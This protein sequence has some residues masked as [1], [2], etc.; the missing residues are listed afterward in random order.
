M[1]P[2]GLPGYAVSPR[3]QRMLGA[4]VPA[5]PSVSG[6]PDTE[7]APALDVYPNALTNEGAHFLIAR[8]G[9]TIAA[10]MGRVALD[11]ALVERNG[12][13]LARETWDAIAIAEG[14]RVVIRATVAGRGFNPLAALLSIAVL[15][16]APALGAAFASTSAFSS[17][18]GGLGIT[19]AAG[20]TALQAGVTAAIGAAGMLIVNTV[21]PPR[22]PDLGGGAG[23][24]V[25]Q[26]SISGGRNPR[27][28]FAPLLLVLGEHRVFPDL[29][30]NPYTEF[31]GDDQ[32]LAQVFDWGLGELDISDIRIGD[33]LL[34]EF[35]DVETSYD[36]PV[37]LVHGNVNT[38][39]GGE[40]EDMDPITRTTA[41]GTGRIGVDLV[42]QHFRSEDDG[43]L[44]GREVDFRIEHRVHGSVGAWLSRTETLSTPDGADARNLVRR[45]VYF[46]VAEGQWDVRVRRT[47]DY[48]ADDERI[49]H[50]AV[51]GALRSYQ[52]DATDWTGR[53]PYAVRIR[54]SGQLQGALDRV[55]G[56]ARQQFQTWAG[57]AWTDAA[58]ASRN[59]AAVLRGYWL[60]WAEGEDKLAGMHLDP[61]TINHDVLGGWYE[62]CDANGLTCDLVLTAQRD[63]DAMNKLIAQCGWATVDRQAGEWSVIWESEDEPVSA[64]ITPA[65]IVAGSLGVVYN[66]DNLADEVIVDYID[67]ESGYQ[68]NTLRRRVDLNVPPIRPVT[69]RLEGVTDGEAAARECNRIAAAQVF[70][71]RAIAWEM[72]SEGLSIRRGRVVALAHDLVG[73]TSGGRLVAID[74]ARTR[75]T[76]SPSVA[77]EG[78]IWIWDLMGDVH[79]SAYTG[80]GD[81]ILLADALPA[82]P[83]G[84]DDDPLAYRWL[85]FAATGSATKV[86]ITGVEPGTSGRTVRVTARDEVTAYYDARTSDLDHP[87]I[88]D[89]VREDIPAALTVTELPDGLRR[90]AWTGFGDTPGV[91]PGGYMIRY[92]SSAAASWE[93]A[94]PLHAGFLTSSPYVTE[95][96]AAGTWTFFIRSV[97][98]DRLGE[99]ASYRAT[100]GSP[101][102]GRELRWR[103]PWAAGADYETGDG[104]SFEGFSY[105][106]KKDHTAS[107]SNAPSGTDNDNDCW[108]VVA[109][110]GFAGEDGNGIEYLFA[111][112][113]SASIPGSQRPLDSWGY[114]VG[115]TV[116]GLTWQD[117]APG[118]TEALGILWRVQR[119]VPG[120]PAVGA[121]VTADWTAPVIVGRYAQ[122]GQDGLAGVAGSD[123]EDGNGLEYLFAVTSSASIPSSQRPL[124][125]W[126]YDDGGTRNGL[127]W[128]DAGPSLTEAVGI[129]WRVQRRIEG[130]PA[131]GESVSGLWSSPRIVGRFGQRGDDG[132]DGVDGGDGADG[133]D[134]DGFERVFAR[135]SGALSSSQY[136]SNTWGYDD[137]G[138]R[139][140]V[141][142]T[143]GS[144][145]LTANLNTLWV[146]KRRIEGA[147]ASG[148][149]I[150]ALWDTPVVVGRFGVDGAAAPRQ[151]TRLLAT[152]VTVESS[153]AAIAFG[154]INSYDVLF[155]ELRDNNTDEPDFKG[156]A[157]IRVADI[158]F[159][160][161]FSDTTGGAVAFAAK[162]DANQTSGV[163][164]QIRR[165]P[166]TSSSII[167]RRWHSSTGGTITGIYGINFGA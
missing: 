116:G 6:G 90:L 107:A 105:R 149:T 140:G 45:S 96:P 1:N 99:V 135:T 163:S 130:A 52:A 56:L 148:A 41:T 81:S 82:A 120:Q 129:L 108:E 28:P 131:I 39:A 88:G 97:L 78:T 66:H 75:L 126:G 133:E 138:T 111:V 27:R 156:S 17:L 112:T 57:G 40:L 104:V 80:I 16:A 142:W 125:S 47:S 134:A 165:S 69:V 4:L 146:A 151:W 106:S 73:G 67:A 162:L 31:E 24:A 8:P 117:G 98:A 92:A 74:A 32:Y 53:S 13:V 42:A 36:S 61:D 26:Y 46:D 64:I 94:F 154:A 87:L 49:L 59:P 7:G 137:G 114:D 85:A 144:E 9:E 55:S 71:T 15:V 23:Q 29:A 113:S 62:F 150:P 19:S 152:A 141:T 95:E 83:S 153:V 18:A 124:D 136:P 65:N 30:S 33:T 79:A 101:P 143:D 37:S 91:E 100:L 63:H 123:G 128:E 93:D 3:V 110:A 115:G 102:V 11:G 25:P 20:L 164:L 77:A 21:F 22:L 160:N 119:R 48:D 35:A 51:W 2:P 118:V 68:S 159:T 72:P 86:R 50:R 38:S 157:S 147:P 76:L 166:G 12:E 132:R 70:H 127:T 158:P 14:D 44:D 54:A 89:G 155:F 109:A 58:T 103:G 145:T 5:P 60:G 10:I 121:D 122:D 139:G 43:D 84:I 167:V 161:T 34:S